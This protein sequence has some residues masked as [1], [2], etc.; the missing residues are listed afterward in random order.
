MAQVR[1]PGT[2]FAA[3][4]QAITIG[5]IATTQAW[6]R[7]AHAIVMA[8]VSAPAVSRCRFPPAAT[9]RCV[10][11]WIFVT[12]DENPPTGNHPLA[13]QPH[14]SSVV[15]FFCPMCGFAVLPVTTS[16]DPNTRRACPSDVSSGQGLASDDPET[17][18]ACPSDVAGTA[19]CWPVCRWA[20]VYCGHLMGSSD[21][22]SGVRGPQ[23]VYG[24]RSFGW[25]LQG[26]GEFYPSFS[27]GTDAG[28]SGEQPQPQE[29]GRIRAHRR[30]GRRTEPTH[31]AEEPDIP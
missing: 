30:H 27:G 24:V 3:D 9:G 20:G 22:W 10:S 25:L 23:L 21:I 28:R 17:G 8:R 13:G 14:S 1:T 19:A 12:G 31:R 15:R 29:T 11:R 7:R 2:T 5:R 18:R 16:D 4:R 6:A 26:A